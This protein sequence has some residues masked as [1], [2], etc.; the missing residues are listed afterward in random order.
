VWLKEAPGKSA[1]ALSPRTSVG[2]VSTPEGTV[3]TP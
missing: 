3:S 1:A 2:S